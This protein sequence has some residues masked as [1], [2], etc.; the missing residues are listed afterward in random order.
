MDWCTYRCIRPHTRI[1]TIH[2]IKQGA[3]KPSWR[4]VIH[5]LSLLPVPGMIA[6]LL[7]KADTPTVCT[8]WLILFGL[9]LWVCL[10]YVHVSSA[11]TPTITKPTPTLQ[12]R[13][14][15]HTHRSKWRAG[16][17]GP[18]AS[19]SS[20][21]PRSTTACAGP[22]AGRCSCRRSTTA[23]S[24]SWSRVRSSFFFLCWACV[25]VALCMYVSRY[26]RSTIVTTKS[27]QH[28]QH[29]STTPQ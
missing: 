3:L 20:S 10:L 4:G 16:S 13:Q 18:A 17:S 9:G 15:H 11:H 1:H 25:C 2:H 6:L 24:S 22:R 8:C 23:L 7:R 29:Q 28:H 14:T 21:A 26:R 12:N 5:G 27:H 19:S